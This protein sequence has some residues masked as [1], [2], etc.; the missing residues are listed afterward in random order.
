MQGE[1]AE[2]SGAE[3][4]TQPDG[5]W[6][7]LLAEACRLAG[8]SRRI[9]V[10]SPTTS[11]SADHPAEAVC[12]IG[13]VSGFFS[14][15]VR[16]QGEWTRHDSGPLVGFLGDE[17]LPVAL[18]PRPGGYRWIDP[19]NGAANPLDSR[20]AEQLLPEAFMLYRK[21]PEESITP[22]RFAGFLL[23]GSARELW[24]IAGAGFGAALLGF[25]FPLMLGQMID[26]AIPEASH[27]GIQQIALGLLVVVV[28]MAL[29]SATRS[30]ALV[31][32][33]GRVDSTVQAAI[34]QRLLSLPVDFFSRFT[35]GDLAF[36]SMGINAIR[37]ILTGLTIN[38][39]LSLVFSMVNLL[40]LFYLDYRLAFAA[41]GLLV[42]QTGYT[43]PIMRKLLRHQTRMYEQQ[44]R[45]AGEILQLLTGIL[46]LRMAAAED[47]AF[48][49]WSG[50]YRSQKDAEYRA[51]LVNVAVSALTGFSPIASTMLLYSLVIWLPHASLSTGH[52]LAFMAAFGGIQS[53]VVQ[54]T[55]VMSTTLDV[56]PMYRRLSPILITQPEN[57]PGKQAP[58]TLSG[59]IAL[60]DVTFAY[61]QPGRD[62]LQHLDLEIKPGE[63]VAVTGTSG[64]GKST[65]LRLLLGFSRTMTGGVYYDGKELD[66]LDIYEVRRQIGIVVQ[67]GRLMGGE[68]YRCIL[69]ERNL[70]LDAAWEAA[71]AVGLE[72]EIKALPMGMNTV[73]PP[74]GE[75][76]SGGQCQR[77]MIAQAIIAKPRIL[78]FDEA[79]SALDNRSQTIV[80]E[81]IARLGATRLVIAH[82]LCTI[83]QADR[84]CV[85]ENGGIVESGTYDE[86]ME[87][88]SAFYRLAERQLI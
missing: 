40:L 21:L 66:S 85:L 23:P 14:R 6:I 24:A 54:M 26:S 34:W 35:A 5:G 19:R 49:V 48:G 55:L 63:F 9:S 42:L 70:G 29:F 81:S 10:I 80:T 2:R 88:K 76:F 1:P 82:R 64:S 18:I 45:N 44:G 38:S 86:L 7:G 60:R 57:P 72:D 62:V 69:G 16:L 71:R 30:F 59:L 27:G 75:T 39:L 15:P 13:R 77:I 58:G 53:A 61:D 56:I 47:R 8:R 22:R 78:F 43:V 36:R 51:G 3:P 73:V 50:T 68:L 84:I 11:C 32:F 41:L 65:L 37:N 52:F 17:R 83:R 4:S 74:G 33:E 12:S 28:S 87:K 46:K 20:G 67:N 79:T 31:R 25:A